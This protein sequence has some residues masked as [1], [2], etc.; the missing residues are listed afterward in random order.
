MVIIAFFKTTPN[1]KPNTNCTPI[2]LKCNIKKYFIVK[3]PSDVHQFISCSYKRNF[4]LLLLI[5]LLQK[6]IN[7]YIN[8][9][10]KF[11]KYALC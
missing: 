3:F 1:P 2:R 4:L 7:I 11:L 6:Y 9:L 8:F 10:M 5:Y